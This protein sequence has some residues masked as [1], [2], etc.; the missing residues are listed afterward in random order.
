MKN[1]RLAAFN[2]LY[3]PDHRINPVSNPIQ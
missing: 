2:A 1:D 3:W